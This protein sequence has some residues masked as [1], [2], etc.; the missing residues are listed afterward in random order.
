MRKY[1]TSLLL[2]PIKKYNTF[3]HKLVTKTDKSK[4]PKKKTDTT[5]STWVISVI[6]LQF[7]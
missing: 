5:L 1:F 6:S 2:L 4:P 3:L 7:T